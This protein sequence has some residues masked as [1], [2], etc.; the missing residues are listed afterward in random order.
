MT[1]HILSPFLAFRPALPAVPA[2]AVL[3][4]LGAARAAEAPS[5]AFRAAS[6]TSAEFDTGAFRGTV[7]LDGAS[8]G[9][10]SFVHA[11]S[12]REIAKAPGLLSYYRVFSSGKRHGDAARD[13]PVRF[14][15][16][17]DGALR[18][19]FAASEE[20]PLELA[21]TFRWRD[22]ATLDLTTTVTP[23]TDLPR[24][25]MFLSSYLAPGSEGFAYLKPNRYAKQGKPAFVRADWSEL[26]D[27]NYL[28]FPR[29][30][31]DLLTIC[32]GRWEIPPSPVSWAF[33]RYLE[34][35]VGLR[36]DAASGLAVALMAPAEDCFAVAL[37][38]NKQPPDNVAGHDSLYLSLFGRDIAAGET[39]TA[40]CRMIAGK[41]LTDEAILERYRAWLA[42]PAP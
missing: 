10:S 11:A 8:Q 40:R 12:G 35:P 5:L 21:G 38:Y 9:I 3:G 27:G 1:R 13:W 18:I 17:D 34:A 19:L 25:E 28:V 14:E 16:L 26:V 39:A 2:L 33:S 4:S 29:R 22:S 23:R 30:P 41:D 6:A 7:R 37:P 31:D 20:H 42:E 32:D 24:F 15:I 36:R